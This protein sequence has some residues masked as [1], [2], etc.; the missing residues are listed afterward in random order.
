MPVLNIPVFVDLGEK[1]TILLII[2]GQKWFLLMNL[3]V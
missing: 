1:Q 3:S 2:F